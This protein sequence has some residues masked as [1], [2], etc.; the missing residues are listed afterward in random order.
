MIRAA[1]AFAACMLM[2]ACASVPMAPAVE[3]AQAKQ[4]EPPADGRATLYIF[5][6]GQFNAAF[7]LSLSVGPR[8]MGQLA[9]DTYFR[10][11][12]DAGEYDVRCMGENTVS[13]PMRLARGETRFLSV[14]PRL[15]VASSRCSAVE[16]DA[17]KG[18][19][20]VMSGQR[21][22]EIR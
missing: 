5:R 19:A 3:D 22:H 16:V 20:G 8:L 9:A 13:V 18:H 2:C 17:A 21:A 4:F 14:S 12:L 10:L 7:T 11:D 6:E 1:L 15:G